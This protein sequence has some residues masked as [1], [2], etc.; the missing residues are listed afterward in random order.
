MI[1]FPEFSFALQGLARLARFD[2]GFSNFFDLSLQGARRSFW[3]SLP[4]LPLFLLSE[5]L[6]AQFP[7]DADLIRIYASELIGYAFFWIAFPLTLMWGARLIDRGPR[8]F[9]AIAVYNWLQVLWVTLTLLITL[10]QYLGLGTGIIFWL[11]IGL[12]AFSLM[13]ETFAFERLLKIGFPIAIALVVIDFAE[14][15]IIANAILFLTSGPLI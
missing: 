10:A 9:G 12:L 2:A 3:L 14:S 6:N 15:Q 5:L 11:R 13:C 7:P 4:V 1:S 8:I